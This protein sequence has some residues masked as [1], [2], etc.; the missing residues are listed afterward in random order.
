[1]RERPVRS[2][3]WKPITKYGIIDTDRK[4]VV[5][6]TLACFTV[7]FAFELSVFRIPLPLPMALAGL[8]LSVSFFRFI[9]FNRRPLWF[10]HRVC[11][12]VEDVTY[13]FCRTVRRALPRDEER[14][15]SPW[16]ADGEGDEV[17]SFLSTGQ[18]QT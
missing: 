16:I 13:L 4:Y 17:L 10:W 3:C 9:R 2:R 6:I 5:I 12:L 7:P 15:A 1:M 11:A 14:R 18:L 8:A